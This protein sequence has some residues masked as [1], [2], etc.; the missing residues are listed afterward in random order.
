MRG[1]TEALPALSAAAGGPAV[2]VARLRG[3]GLYQ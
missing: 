2:A 3:T 1:Q